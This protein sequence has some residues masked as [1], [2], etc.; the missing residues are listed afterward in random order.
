M[1]DYL[2]I[3][4]VG[5]AWRKGGVRY[6]YDF[7]TASQANALMSESGSTVWLFRLF[8]IFIPC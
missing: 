3:P 2:K 1:E 5:A 6:M 7:V 8:V 4:P